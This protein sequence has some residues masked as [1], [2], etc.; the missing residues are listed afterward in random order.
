MATDYVGIGLTIVI[1]I[2]IL[3]LV[4]ARVQ[5]DTVIEILG[6]IRDFLKGE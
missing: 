5:G 1:V 6:E 3:L 4:W 2:F